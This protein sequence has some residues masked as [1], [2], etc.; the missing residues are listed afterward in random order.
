MI[1]TF[2]IYIDH[3]LTIISQNVIT[4]F[5]LK[6]LEPTIFSTMSDQNDSKSESEL[7]SIYISSE[8]SII[9]DDSNKSSTSKRKKR[10]KRCELIQTNKL[11]RQRKQPQ[12]YGKSTQKRYDDVIIDL[13]MN[14]SDKLKSNSSCSGEEINIIQSFCENIVKN[15]NERLDSFKK[16]LLT[17]INSQLLRLEGKF[18]SERIDEPTRKRRRLLSS[19]SL[20][21]SAPIHNF[22]LPLKTPEDVSLFEERLESD[23]FKKSIFNYLI[24][25]NGNNGELDAGKLIKGIFHKI[26]TKENLGN[27]T[28]AGK[29]K[30]TRKFNCHKR[31]LGLI[32][33]LLQAADSSYDRNLFDRDVVERVFKYAYQ[34]RRSNPNAAIIENNTNEST[35][36]SSTQIIVR[37]EQNIP[38]NQPPSTLIDRNQYIQPV[39]P[40][41]NRIPFDFTNI[42]RNYDSNTAF[43]SA[44]NF[45]SNSFNRFEENIGSGPNFYNL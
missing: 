6:K 16:R 13:E 27:F 23:D 26:F 32:F 40:I 2:D 30:Q 14:R 31:I 35:A 19:E 4:F 36:S 15:I 33:E 39:Q 42:S 22:G 37:S 20:P 1:S 5:I 41:P 9:N 3:N 38:N 25:I 21:E 8:D 7:E 24:L 12:R 10:D 45:Q 44:S 34:G 28:Y 11:K 18:I 29:N 17:G 43:H